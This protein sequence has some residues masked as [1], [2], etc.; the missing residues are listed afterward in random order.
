M[1]IEAKREGVLLAE[2]YNSSKHFVGGQYMSIKLDGQR[3]WWDGGI[4]TGLPVESIPWAYNPKPGLK[5]T[6][7]WSRNF[8]V[9]CAG[10]AWVAKLPKGLPLDGEV[11]IGNGGFED[12]ESIVRSEHYDDK[13]WATVGYHCFDRPGYAE[14]FRDGRMYIR[15]EN[16]YINCWEWVEKRL[17]G[18]LYRNSITFDAA[19]EQIPEEFRLAQVKLPRIEKE[20]L[21]VV[22]QKL[23]DVTD[24]GGEGVMIRRGDSIWTPKRSQH[25]LKI[26]KFYD[27]EGEVTGYQDGE[28]RLTGSLG[29][30]K[31]K[32]HVPIKIG[33]VLK[34]L[35]DF[36][37]SG[38]TDEERAKAKELFP[39]G[40]TVT[41]R[42]NEITDDGLPR[43]G[44]YWRKRAK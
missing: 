22:Y 19:L 30:L 24:A 28:G 6:G 20:A 15:K 12:L 13:R 17:L 11:W 16:H 32:G 36:K 38:F 8:K 43:F 2:D 29:A 14:L 3:V 5:A 1:K 27:A 21:E 42:Y 35:R 34:A 18:G 26:K 33:S 4:S 7:L 37:I 39:I 25:L 9:I 23:N 44:R 10:W 40:T 31:L 41:Y